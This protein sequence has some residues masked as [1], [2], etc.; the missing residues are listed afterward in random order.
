MRET[1]Y[2]EAELESRVDTY[3][4]DQ[5]DEMLSRKYQVIK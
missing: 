2:T 4:G 1:D 3:F 5:K